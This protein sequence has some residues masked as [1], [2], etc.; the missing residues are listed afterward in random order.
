MC[1]YLCVFVCVC[2]CEREREREDTGK[3]DCVGGSLVERELHFL[4]EWSDY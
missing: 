3:C 1:V 4:N 2:V